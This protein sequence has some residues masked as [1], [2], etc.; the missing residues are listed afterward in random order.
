MATE[1][2]PSSDK[3]HGMWIK[4]PEKKKLVSRP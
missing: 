1:Q 4:V 3:D 2:T